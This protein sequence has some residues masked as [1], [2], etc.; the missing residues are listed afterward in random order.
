MAARSSVSPCSC[1][2][3]GSHSSGAVYLHSHGDPVHMLYV[4]GWSGRQGSVV[5]MPASDSTNPPP[6][7]HP[8]IAFTW[9]IIVSTPGAFHFAIV[10]AHV[11]RLLLVT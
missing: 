4:G 10:A 7:L 11:H 2:H 1:L 6:H 5:P 9:R 3:G 8:P